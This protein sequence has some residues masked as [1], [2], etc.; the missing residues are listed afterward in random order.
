MLDSLLDQARARLADVPREVLGQWHT[1]KKILGVARAERIIRVGDAW[2]VGALL[3]DDT[4]VYSV[5][6]IIRAQDPGRRGYTAESQRE[7]AAV[8][9]AALLGGIDEGTVVHLGWERLDLAALT[10]G[11]EAGPLSMAGD[12]PMIRW[13]AAGSP[14]PLEGYL[15][16]R[17]DLLLGQ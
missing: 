7:R 9:A 11:R 14:I 13:S 4:A 6:E 3:I 5:G 17:V 8:R 15:A 2:H 1:P 16:E 10:A 12:V